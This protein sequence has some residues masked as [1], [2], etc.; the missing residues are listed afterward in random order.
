MFS[1][2]ALFPSQL[3][4]VPVNLFAG[5]KEI[6]SL[7]PEMWCAGS[8]HSLGKVSELRLCAAEGPAAAAGLAV[9]GWTRQVR[10]S[11]ARAR[12]A[13]AI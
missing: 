9:W 4:S 11:E 10:G 13:A 6:S 5:N 3:A 1:L 12:A 8:K 7:L 2:Q